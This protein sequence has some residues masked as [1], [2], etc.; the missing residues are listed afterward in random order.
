MDDAKKL[1]WAG[2]LYVLRDYRQR[3]V[4]KLLW[5]E[6]TKRIT[7]CGAACIGLSTFHEHP[8]IP[9]YELCG[10]REIHTEYRQF[11]MGMLKLFSYATP[12]PLL[13]SLHPNSL[14]L[15]PPTSTQPL[16]SLGAH[17]ISSIGSS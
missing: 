2:N 6:L 15:P 9:F 5:T 4:A 12:T 17:L 8:L 11:Y 1:A 7:N 13:H 10:F 3:G 16:L 14:H